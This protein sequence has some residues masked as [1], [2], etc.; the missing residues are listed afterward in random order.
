MRTHYAMIF[1]TGAGELTHRAM[2]KRQYTRAAMRKSNHVARTEND[3]VCVMVV[4][5]ESAEDRHVRTLL[6][7]ILREEDARF[8]HMPLR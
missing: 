2:T 8:R 4:Y 6:I 7:E 1:E 3:R 5:P